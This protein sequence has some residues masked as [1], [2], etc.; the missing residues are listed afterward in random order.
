MNIHLNSHFQLER[1][2]SL[3]NTQVWF[4]SKL[5]PINRP[6]FSC[7]LNK[8]NFGSFISSFQ[9][10]LT[11]SMEGNTAGNTNLIDAFQNGYVNVL[12]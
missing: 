3:E 7:F 11:H 4:N 5:S 8:I 2:A 10:D 9:L 1:L 12:L 6:L